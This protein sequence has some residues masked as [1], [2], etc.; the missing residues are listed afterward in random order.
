MKLGLDAKRAFHNHSGLGVY[1]RGLISFIEKTKSNFDVILFTPKISTKLFHSK[2][3]IQ[4]SKLG[5]LWRSILIYF[6]I[7]NHKLDIYHGLAGELPF[8]IPEK[9]KKIVTIHDV[10]FLR[11]PKDYPWIDRTIYSIKAKYACLQSD[12]IIA[13]SHATKK[14]IVAYYSISPDKIEVIPNCFDIDVDSNLQKPNENDY[15]VCISSFLPRKNQK[16]LI[17][18]YISIADKV[19]FDLVLIGSGGQWVELN[20]YAKKSQFTDR[21]KFVKNIDD[22]TKF[23]YLIHALFSVYPSMYE[24]FGIPIIESMAYQTP[25][26]VSDTEIH[27]EVAQDAAIYFENNNSNELAQKM[28]E[29]FQINT[30]TKTNLIQKGLQRVDN[31]K[32]E[33]N[34]PK[35][36]ELYHSI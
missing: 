21:I 8:W 9:V 25:I 22:K 4:G 12:K 17:D 19:D 31:Y 1:S 7:K 32:V 13:V 26:I 28:I 30:E 34:L 3:K 20:S 35:L 16:L 2:F 27:R 29:V 33:K 10:L 18:A 14:D 24:G 36:I 23:A 15:I 6:D 5:S 11:F